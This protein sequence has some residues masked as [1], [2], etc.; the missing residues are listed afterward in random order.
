M[1]TLLSV[2]KK[3]FNV[4]RK[5]SSR[6]DNHIAPLMGV[7]GVTLPSIRPL[8]LASRKQ[9]GAAI[10]SLGGAGVESGV[11]IAGRAGKTA[12]RAR[13]MG[14]GRKKQIIAGVRGASTSIRKNRRLIGDAATGG[15]FGLTGAVNSLVK[16]SP[17]GN[18]KVGRLLTTDISAPLYKKARV[19]QR[20]RTATGGVFSSNLKTTTF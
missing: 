17:I 14:M 16:N 7:G 6:V 12:N 2:A 9:K 4:V 18:T 10:A 20:L 11:R 15:T 19:R 5:A 13:R 8:A 3:S 1:A